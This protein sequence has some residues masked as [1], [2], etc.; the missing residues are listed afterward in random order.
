MR[1]LIKHK[2]I[3]WITTT[4]ILFSAALFYV[5]VFVNDKPGGLSDRRMSHAMGLSDT[6]HIPLGETPEDAIQQ[7]RGFQ[8]RQVIHREPVDGGILLFMKRFNQDDA[9]NLQVEYVRKTWLGWKWVW[10]GGFAIG[11][12]LQT[13][14]AL[15][16]MSMPKLD[17][18]S[19]PFPMVFGE[20]MDLSIKNVTVEINDKSKH[21]AKLTE[22][23]SG[24]MIWFVF[25]PSSASTPFEIEG[26]NEE[27]SLIAYKTIKDPRDS[28]SIDLRD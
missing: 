17:K 25:L 13:K 14:T 19:T 24:K 3:V 15:N 12:S 5:L 16:Y 2:R 21:N 4:L 27:G 6:I 18:I 11:E 9:S 10:G 26:Y 28:G 8:S 7:F 22:V 23:D 1:I 20:V